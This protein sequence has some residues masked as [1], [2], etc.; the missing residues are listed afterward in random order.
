MKPR[1]ISPAGTKC[2]SCKNNLKQHPTLISFDVGFYR[3]ELCKKNWAEPGDLMQQLG[4][5][6]LG[7]KPILEEVDGEGRRIV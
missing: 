7:R 3:C 1:R 5:W 6:I 2:P 4:D